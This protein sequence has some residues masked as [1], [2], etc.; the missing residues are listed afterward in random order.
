M[1]VNEELSAEVSAWSDAQTGGANAASDSDTAEQSLQEAV[2]AAHSADTENEPATV[3][4]DGGLAEQQSQRNVIAHSDEQR[5]KTFIEQDV[6][7]FTRKY[8]QFGAEE[9]AALENNAQFR[10]FCGSRFGREPLAELYG[11]YRELLG[12]INAAAQVRAQSRARRSTGSGAAGGAMLTPQQKG[13]L[14][15]W[16]AEHPEMAMTAGEFLKR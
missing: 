14:D 4:I 7:E 15:A 3:M 16:N 5:Q 9:L 6:V 11:A 8:P 13:A 2:S 12:G 1:T 10:R